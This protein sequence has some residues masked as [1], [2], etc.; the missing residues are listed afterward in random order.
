MKANSLSSGELARRA[1]VSRDTLR[2]YER[3]GLLALPPRG[4]NGY[5]RYPESALE[6]VHLIRRALHVGFTIEELCGILRARD[7]GD[8][9]CLHV[10][11]IA[12]RR[13]GEIEERLSDLRRLRDELRTTLT[14]WDQRLAHTAPGRR[15]RLLESLPGPA[16]N[17]AGRAAA[18]S[19]NNRPKRENT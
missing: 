4:P 1:D 6:R 16:K 3:Q 7:R 9:P 5:R 15:A 10:R 13:L 12:A 11:E 17:R 8:A 19:S 14:G 2:H 18:F